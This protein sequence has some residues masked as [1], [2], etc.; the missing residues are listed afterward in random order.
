MIKKI[1]MWGFCFFVG[2]WGFLFAL[3]FLN[4]SL[5]LNS[6]GGLSTL[7]FLQKVTFRSWVWQKL[8]SK[9]AI[10]P[11]NKALIPWIPALWHSPRRK[12]HSQSNHKFCLCH[13]LGSSSAFI[14]T[15]HQEP[16]SVRQS[17]T[18]TVLKLCVNFNT[19]KAKPKHCMTYPA[20]KS[21]SIQNVASVAGAVT[22][23]FRNNSAIHTQNRWEMSWMSN[24]L[25]NKTTVS[26][27]VLFG[28]LPKALFTFINIGLLSTFINSTVMKINTLIFFFLTLSTVYHN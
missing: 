15:H 10:T 19:Q 14:S 4:T 28:H 8:Q 16:G 27:S 26:T 22:L 12:E 1:V 20:T 25:P 23:R 6:S 21:W 9:S 11:G 13:W 5:Q 24:W 3:L 2:T 7:S 18:T 17:E